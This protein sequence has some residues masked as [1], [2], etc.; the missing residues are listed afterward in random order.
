MDPFV[1]PQPFGKDNTIYGRELEI[2]ELRYLVGAK[3]IVLLHSPSGAGKSSLLMAANG[4]LAKLRASERFEIFGPARVNVPSSGAQNRFAFSAINEFEKRRAE[5]ARPPET[6]ATDT[7]TSYLAERAPERSP[8]LIFDQFEEVLSEDAGNKQSKHAFFDQLGELLY[9][10]HV[11]ALFVI[12]EDFLAALQPYAKQVPTHLQNRYRL[13]LLRR[14]DQAIHC[15]VQPIVQQGRHF[16]P[17]VAEGVLSDLSSGGDTVEPLQLQVVGTNL[18]RNIKDRDPAIAIATADFGRIDDALSSYYNSQVRQPDDPAL[19]RRIRQWFGQELISAGKAR[20]LV[21]EDEA[22]A[23]LPELVL[24][25]LEGS[26]LIR[27]ELRAKRLWYEL[28][29]DRLVEP[30]RASNAD[31]EAKTLVKLQRDAALWE[32]QGFLPGLLHQGQDLEDSRAWA[33]VNAVEE[34]ERRFLAES[35]AQQEAQ[36]RDRRRERRLRFWL[37]AAVAALL[38]ALAAGVFAYAKY[39]EANRQTTLAR[40]SKSQAEA[41]TRLAHWTA[42][43][44][45]GSRLRE[46]HQQRAAADQ[47]QKALAATQAREKQAR[48]EALRFGG[49]AIVAAFDEKSGLNEGELQA[50]RDLAGG[51]PELR[52]SALIGFLQAEASSAK[53]LAHQGALLDA[54]FILSPA[55]RQE[56]VLQ[57]MR[58]ECT[59]LSQLDLLRPENKGKK[60]LGSKLRQSCLLL[61]GELTGEIPHLNALLYDGLNDRFAC[62][63]QRALALSRRLPPDLATQRVKQI[64]KL[65]AQ[66]RPRPKPANAD[67]L[68]VN[69]S[70]GLFDSLEERLGTGAEEFVALAPQLTP[71]DR[72]NTINLLLATFGEVKPPTNGSSTMTE[73]LLKLG[74]LVPKVQFPVWFNLMLKRGMETNWN[75]ISY[76]RLAMDLSGYA[77]DLGPGQAMRAIELLGKSLQRRGYEPELRASALEAFAPFVPAGER[78]AAA[79]AVTALMTKGWDRS[80]QTPSSPTALEYRRPLARALAQWGFADA[81]I[82]ALL[83]QIRTK[84]IERTKLVDLARTLATLNSAVTPAQVHEVASMLLPLALKGDRLQRIDALSALGAF[85][86]RLGETDARQVIDLLKRNDAATKGIFDEW[87]NTAWALRALSPRLSKADTSEMAARLPAEGGNEF[88]R[89][90]CTWAIT[91]APDVSSDQAWELMR[92][93]LGRLGRDSDEDMLVEIAKALGPRLSPQALP[94]TLEDLQRLT[95]TKAAAAYPALLR[96]ANEAAVEAMLKLRTVRNLAKGQEDAFCDL[97]PALVGLNRTKLN[98]QVIEDIVLRPTCAPKQ[99]IAALRSLAAALK[100]Q[101]DTLGIVDD[102]RF[103]RAVLGRW[104]TSQGY[105]IT[106][107]SAFPKQ[108]EP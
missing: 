84:G 36:E 15:L 11:W 41:Q 58:A 70:V 93:A 100:Q 91:V 44:A 34:V 8:L 101:P 16:A 18:W 69:L 73:E 17:G 20:H 54:L 62:C 98:R 86:D 67:P 42:W 47:Q 43:R 108:V 61:A 102:E 27:K 76:G 6:F 7:L 35:I 60:P 3:R 85:G 22:K 31:W 50:L 66:A 45:E 74:A 82:P 48:E 9:Q 37:R 77:R 96:N 95:G 4:L 23:S 89:W 56:P 88:R 105:R 99:R 97:A 71:A 40:E 75:D 59:G 63:R 65:I 52:Q 55:E 38:L 28:S 64:E 21:P 107:I 5:G 81:P 14:E 92:Q 104:A 33:A 39:G 83:S 30:V 29:H 72:H 51:S 46:L 13:D 24:K 79:R 90:W 10:P 94:V 2:S 19:E 68:E 78:A 26:Y 32:Q 103:D 49:L 80:P 57:A 25:R 1:G 106:G 87:D 53:F 12:R